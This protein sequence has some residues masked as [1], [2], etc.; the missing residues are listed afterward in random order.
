MMRVRWILLAGLLAVGLSLAAASPARA[1]QVD[2]ALG[3]F[4][5]YP[6]YYFPHDYWPTQGPQ[7]P[8]PPGAPY[9][10]PPAY[11]AYPP[12]NEPHWRYEYLTPQRY[13]RGFHFWLDQF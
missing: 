5:Y 6:Y 12:F 4:F 8:E 9:M 11:M 3:R 7:W 2:P 10:R 1:Q 13:Y